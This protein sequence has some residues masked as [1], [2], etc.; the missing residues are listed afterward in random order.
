MV[1]KGTVV[2]VANRETPLENHSGVLKVTDKGILVLDSTAN[3]TVWSSN[4]TQRTAGNKIN[5]PIAKLL[6]TGNLVV[7]NENISDQENFL[8]QSFDY[9]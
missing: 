4:N 6:D 3:T 7:K 9:P 2:W 5:S 1:S 8:W